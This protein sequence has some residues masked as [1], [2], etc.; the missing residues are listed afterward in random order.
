MSYNGLLIKQ[1]TQVAL[2]AA[3]PLPAHPPVLLLCG[4]L[5]QENEAGTAFKYDKQ[6][7][8]SELFPSI[9]LH[10]CSQMTLFSW[11]HK[12]PKVLLMQSIMM[13]KNFTQLQ[14]K[15]WG[16]R[17]KEMHMHY[18]KSSKGVELE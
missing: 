15:G 4:N 11:S 14:L 16:Y 13:M 6:V 18:C 8:Q 7:G 2:P 10:A 5:I 17:A 3:V 12:H 9:F 1:C